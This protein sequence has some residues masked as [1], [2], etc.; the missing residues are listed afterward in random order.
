M[1]F[2]K[3]KETTVNKWRLASLV[4]AIALAVTVFIYLIAQ[5]EDSYTRIKRKL[6]V[7]PSGIATVVGEVEPVLVGSKRVRVAI[8]ALENK[9]MLAAQV[10][11][12]S[13][14]AL[15]PQSKVSLYWVLMESP[16]S[17]IPAVY[18]VTPLG[19]K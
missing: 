7:E 9:N 3:E 10:L 19:K 17:Q 8:I 15:E 16:T 13:D 11:S 6:K 1:N 4:L 2:D 14:E 12:D 18:F 5:R